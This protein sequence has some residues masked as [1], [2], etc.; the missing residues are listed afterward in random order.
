MKKKFLQIV[1]TVLA[2]VMILP[3]AALA[4]ETITLKVGESETIE[5]TTAT[6]NFP[7]I[8]WESSDETVAAVAKQSGKQKTTT[9]TGM[10]AG[11]ATI[12]GTVVNKDITQTF[13]VAVTG[14][15]E[16]TPD[17]G[18]NET[19]MVPVDPEEPE[20]PE[21]KDDF[22]ITCD[23]DL[24][25]YTDG[26]KTIQLKVE[27]YDDVMWDSDDDSVASVSSSGVVT[28]HTAGKSVTIHAYSK[29]KSTS[30]TVRVV[31]REVE[32]ISVSGTPKKEY[33]EG[34]SFSMGSASVVAH[35]N[36]GTS[37]TV[38]GYTVKPS[39]ILAQEDTS[40]T[41][42]Y[43]GKTCEVTGIKVTADSVTGIEIVSPANGSKYTVGDTIKRSDVSIKVTRSGGDKYTISAADY[44]EI[45]F[46]PSGALTA[47]DKALT[48]S[49]SGKTASIA[50]SVAEKVTK[51]LTD[52]KVYTAPTKTVYTTNE[53]L[54]LTGLVLA[55]KYSD[56]TNNQYVTKTY[57]QNSSRISANVE[58]FTREGTQNVTVTYTD[59][60]GSGSATFEVTVGTFVDVTGF[61]NTTGNKAVLDE[62]AKVKIDDELDW[63]DLFES[64]SFKYKNS[65]GTTKYKKIKDEDDL[66]DWLG[67]GAKMYVNVS[68]KD[69][70]DAD[71][72]EE[73]DIKNGKVSLKLYLEYG[74]KTYSLSFDMPISGVACT[75][76]IYRSA[77]SSSVTGDSKVFDDLEEALESLEDED[78]II[79][80]YNV[81]SSYEKNFAVKIK[82]GEDQDI[83]GFEFAPD[84]EHKITIDLNGCELTLDSEW[85]E[86]DSKNED[87]EIVITNT[88]DDDHGT[89]VYDDLDASLVVTDGS[90]LKFTEGVIPMDSD[91]ECTVSIYKNGNSTSSSALLKTKVYDS[92][93]EALEDLEDHDDALDTFDIDDDYEDSFV[94]RMKLGKDQNLTTF[95]FA[96][97]YDTTVYI[98][99][100]GYTLKLK[101]EWI[102]YEDCEDLVVYVNNTHKDKKATLTYNDLS[103]SISIAKGDS[104][105]KFEEDTIPGIYKVTIGSTSNGKVTVSPNKT[106]VAHGGTVTFTI[107]PNEGYEISSVKDGTKTISSATSGYTV[108]SK[109]VGTY[110]KENITA[111][112]TL[113]VTFKK[114][115]ASS[116]STTSSA[117]NWTNPF[118]DVS[119]NAQYYD[120]VAFV[121]SEGLFNGMTATKFEPTT[122]MTRA[123]FV[124]VL[125]RLAGV[126]VNRYSG[127]SFTDVSKNDQQISWAAPYIEWAVQ[128][129]ITNGTGN[130]KFSPND[131]ITHQQMYLFMKRYADEIAKVDTT[132]TGVSLSSIRDASE[133]ADWAEEGVKFASKYGILIT[134]GGKLT[135]TDNALR[136]ELAMLLHGFCVKVLGK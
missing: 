102:D 5:M 63:E 78:D 134:S 53:K 57:S 105:L 4:A 90:N 54:D 132:T 27:G 88:N 91:A 47:S 110:K 33:T 117:A 83:E 61:A 12:T 98:D 34:E 76:T 16:Q 101:S 23:D 80:E 100:N 1:S 15:G 74:G 2:V 62:D 50:I 7:T 21:E 46:S 136:C 93:K 133:I 48:V 11:T 32:E 123:M 109:G 122:T 56:S 45:T 3:T 119:K 111:D 6:G 106:T 13:T 24:T 49:Y 73:D 96:P 135:P 18:E 115:A 52:V 92:L 107:T 112:V 82:L 120:A 113:D 39:G 20:T 60:F 22:E 116:S 97:D 31:K 121:C 95:I 25:V 41:I 28:G 44:S 131:P 55:V 130:G 64:V 77:T 17:S 66:E 10:S 104:S 127:T 75:V 30:C 38:T 85:I 103:S 14:D 81:G 69:G 19:P 87:I 126:D 37:E 51:T 68:G 9:V 36:D 42:T 40:V 89:L 65:S 79:D 29:G 70:S 125:G 118:T 26:G 35:Y 72:V 124:T 94:V 84:H 58:K 129:G 43:A 71:T 59:E 114:S 99:L 108:S 8:T 128:V 86:Y 67:A